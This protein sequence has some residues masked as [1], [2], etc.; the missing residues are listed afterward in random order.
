MRQVAQA[1]GF[2]VA[3]VHKAYEYVQSAVSRLERVEARLEG[4]LDDYDY[5]GVGPVTGLKK[6]MKEIDGI[7]NDRFQQQIQ[8]IQQIGSG[9]PNVN[10]LI[11][12]SR[13]P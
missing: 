13:V 8:S 11:T 9:S 6:R 1:E 3:P 7:I 2:A 12:G 4:Q 5:P 10:K